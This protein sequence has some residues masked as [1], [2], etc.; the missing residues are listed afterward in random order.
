MTQT[1]AFPRVVQAWDALAD[2]V[3]AGLKVVVVDDGFGLDHRL[4]PLTF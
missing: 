1:V 4:Q 3:V 2:K